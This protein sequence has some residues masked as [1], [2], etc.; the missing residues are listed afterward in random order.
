MSRRDDDEGFNFDDIEADSSPDVPAPSAIAAEDGEVGDVF[1]VEE[2][3]A[4]AADAAQLPEA[5]VPPPEDEE[6]R[7]PIRWYRHWVRPKFLQYRYM[8]DYRTNYYNDVIEYLDKRAKGVHCEIPRA[9]T[10][11]ERVLRTHTNPTVLDYYKNQKKEDKHLI[12]V[13]AA[14]IRTHNYHTKAYINQRYASV[15]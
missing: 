1:D 7:R 8:Y 14:S 15:L 2:S 3:A 13:I 11:A 9:Q 10:W 12:Q 6:M 5:E 4:A